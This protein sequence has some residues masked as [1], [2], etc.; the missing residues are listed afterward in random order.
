M[1]NESRKYMD[2]V[3]KLNRCRKARQAGEIIDRITEIP[4]RSPYLQP[5]VEFALHSL[6]QSLQGLNKR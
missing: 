3:E 1:G 2:L 6:R 5:E 4:V